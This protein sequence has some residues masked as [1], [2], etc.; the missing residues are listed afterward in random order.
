MD[1]TRLVPLRPVPLPVAQAALFWVGDV[2]WGRDPGSYYMLLMRTIANADPENR[3][4]LATVYPEWV[5]AVVQVMT[6]L[7]FE[8]LREQVQG[9]A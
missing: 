6:T 5:D 4:L 9:H 2:V 3:A 1:A 8:V 7:G